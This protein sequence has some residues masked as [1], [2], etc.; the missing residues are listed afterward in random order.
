[1]N[2]TACHEEEIHIPGHIQSFGFLIV[3][4]SATKTVKFYSENIVPLFNLQENIF[5]KTIEELGTTFPQIVESG[6]LSKINDDSTRENDQ[7]IFRISIEWDFYHCIMYRVGEHIFLEFEKMIE[8]LTIRSF[9]SAKYGAVT[10]PDNSQTIW[11]KLLESID[12]IVDYD[13]LMVYKFQSDGSG[14]VVAEKIKEG[15]DSYLHFHYPESDIPRQARELYLLKQNRIFSNVYEEPVRILSKSDEKIDLTYCSVRA[16][17]PIHAQYLKNTGVSSSFSTSIIVENKL[18]GL[19]TCQNK[20]PK[21]IDMVNR[22]RAEVLTLLAANAYFTYKTNQRYEDSVQINHRIS[23]LKKESLKTGNLKDS[24]FNNIELIKDTVSSDGLAVITGGELKT[25]GQVPSSET[26]FKISEWVVSHSDEN[27]YSNSSF[28]AQHKID[29]GLDENAAGILAAKWYATNNEMLIWFRKEYDEHIKKA[30]YEQKETA[31][32]NYYGDERLMVSPRKSF[33]VFLEQI[34]GKSKLWQDKD[35]LAAERI[36]THILETSYTQTIEVKELNRALKNLNN[37]LESF[38][39]TISHDLATPLSVIKLN[40]QM[41]SNAYPEDM[42]IK[43]KML[44]ITQ[45]I[46]G[47]ETMM[48]NILELSRVKNADLKLEKVST[49]QIIR[50]IS[51]DAKLSFMS[52]HA[53]VTFTNF[54][55]VLADKTMLYQVFL[56][57]INN[58]V[59][60]SAHREKP[61]IVITATEDADCVVYAVSDNGIGIIE[62]DSEKM[63]KVFSRMDNAKVFQG[64][65]VGLVIV[66]RI[67]KRIGGTVTYKSR[68]NEGSTFY[69]T[70]LKPS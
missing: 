69:L 18:W 4:D 49:E 62:E 13:R 64:T 66:E 37:E 35:L 51:Y 11:M 28:L 33:E 45:E 15:I 32:V 44:K 57:I 3:L 48:R 36:L 29:L 34:K 8:H 26:I 67:M 6:I 46:D 39:F 14:K 31:K 42:K 22:V 41:L 19:V 55:E 23:E 70:F 58:A 27:I 2:F 47:M 17:S 9:M 10:A 24:L 52:E 68:I 43:E 5:G 54:P 59:K 21:H 65:G 1:M 25:V 63:F 56:N 12:E 30:G 38:S 7:N 20:E 60:Y 40:A 61:Q 50:K 53:E 16:M